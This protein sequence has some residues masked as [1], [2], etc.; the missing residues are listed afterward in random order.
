[1][2][3]VDIH[4]AAAILR[5][6]APERHPVRRAQRRACDMPSNAARSWRATAAFE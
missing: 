6:D 5:Q 2:L 4:A 1:M 3:G